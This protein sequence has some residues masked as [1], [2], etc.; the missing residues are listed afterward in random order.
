MRSTPHLTP[1][2]RTKPLVLGCGHGRCPKRNLF[3]VWKLPLQNTTAWPYGIQVPCVSSPLSISKGDLGNRGIWMPCA[4]WVGG[5][6]FC[7]R[8]S[9]KKTRKGPTEFQVD[10]IHSHRLPPGFPP[11]HHHPP[12]KL[13]SGALLLPYLVFVFHHHH[14]P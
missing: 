3:S 7:F 11:Y 9:K 13:T 6:C 4:V 10:L 5:Q 14:R 8:W 1:R 2:V 12:I